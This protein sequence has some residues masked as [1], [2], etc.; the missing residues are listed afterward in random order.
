MQ[1]A[2]AH[3]RKQFSAVVELG[4]LDKASP[5]DIVNAANEFLDV[6]L[7]VIKKGGKERIGFPKEKRDQKGLLA[8][9]TEGFYKGPLTGEKYQSN[10]HRPLEKKSASKSQPRSTPKKDGS[11]KKKR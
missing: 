1:F 3:M 11:G 9:L 5:K 2:D 4:V 10:S 6:P 7:D 8:L